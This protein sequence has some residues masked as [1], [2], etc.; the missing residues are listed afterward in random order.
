MKY[1]TLDGVDSSTIT[2]H[3]AEIKLHLNREHKVFLKMKCVIPFQLYV[4]F[5]Q[6]VPR[7][8]CLY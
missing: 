7:A 3:R 5:C 1:F 4:I 8:A 2:I 6:A